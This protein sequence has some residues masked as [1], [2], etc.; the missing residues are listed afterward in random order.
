[1]SVSAVGSILSIVS[2]LGAVDPA[3]QKSPQVGAA[4][5]EL[6]Q[7]RDKGLTAWAHDQKIEALR[8]K[9]RAQVLSD[10]KLSEQGLESL[11]ADQKSSVEQ[12][13]ARLIEQKLQETIE[14]SVQDAARRGQTQGVFLDIMA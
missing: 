1:M 7:I 13:I 11:P 14:R 9:I 8:E 6:E 10:N 3:R 2:G 5:T 12:E 4:S